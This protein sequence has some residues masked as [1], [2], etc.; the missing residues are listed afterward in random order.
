MFPGGQKCRENTALKQTHEIGAVALWLFWKMLLLL[1]PDAVQNL[2]TLLRGSHPWLSVHSRLL[3]PVQLL[4]ARRDALLILRAP[5]LASVDPSSHPHYLFWLR[6]GH[7]TTGRRWV[8]S[9]K[10]SGSRRD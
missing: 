7:H 9:G 10:G 4:P 8:V 1:D 2:D 5:T 6:A 3:G